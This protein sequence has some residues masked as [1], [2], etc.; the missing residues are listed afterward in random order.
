MLFTNGAIWH[1]CLPNNTDESHVGFLGMYNRSVIYPQEDMS[2]QLTDKELEGESDLLKQLLG[3]KI[4]FRDPDHGV[5]RRRT[6]TGFV[7]FTS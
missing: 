2:R 7:N 5:N 4:P 3:R 6:E 1:Q